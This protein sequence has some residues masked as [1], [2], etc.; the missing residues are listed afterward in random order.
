MN[1]WLQRLCVFGL[2]SALVAGGLGWATAESLRME[3][4]QRESEAREK[5]AGKVRL[6]LWRLDGQIAPMLAREDGR[7]YAH[8]T[9]LHSPIPAISDH[10]TIYEPGQVRVPSP[11]L[12]EQLPDWMMLHFQVH[13]TNKW[14]SPQVL[15]RT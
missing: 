13:P 5:R 14:Q 4:N 8:F 2:I 6:A 15:S 11:L 1:R 3:R 7:S 12:E 10:G 9:P